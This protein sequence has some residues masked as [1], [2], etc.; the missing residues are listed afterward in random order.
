MKIPFLLQII[1]IIIQSKQAE[2]QFTLQYLYDIQIG[3]KLTDIKMLIDLTLSTN[4]IFSN[5]DRPYAQK[6]LSETRII[7]I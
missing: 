5:T 1:Y 7:F 6:I 2:K 4:I 3:E